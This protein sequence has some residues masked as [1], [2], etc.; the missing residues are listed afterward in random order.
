[1][2]TSSIFS[3]ELANLY[4]E[5]NVKGIEEYVTSCIDDNGGLQ[6]ERFV[7]LNPRF[8]KDETLNL[9][10]KEVASVF[11][12]STD[13]LVKEMKMPIL[14]GLDFF[15]IPGKF[16]LQKSKIYT[17]GR[18]YGQDLSS[19]AAVAA[20]SI[21]QKCVSSNEPFKVLDLCCCPGVK[22]CAIADLIEGMRKASTVK[23]ISGDV[24]MGVDIDPQRLYVCRKIVKKYHID[25]LL[26]SGSDCKMNDCDRNVR[27]MLYNSDGT[28]FSVQNRGKLF[29]DTVAEKEELKSCKTGNNRKRMNKS[30][31]ARERKRL[32]ALEKSENLKNNQDSNQDGF[33]DRVLVD[34]ECSTDGSIK[35]LL[36]RMK[37]KNDKD[38]GPNEKLS[39]KVLSSNKSG[40]L[41]E[42][43]KLQRN[44][45]VAGFQNLRKDGV[46]V[47]STC[48]L[49]RDQNEE[50]VRHLLE[51]FANAFIIP[52]QSNDVEGFDGYAFLSDWNTIRFTFGKFGGFFLAK[53]GKR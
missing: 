1:M 32:K 25:S 38:V 22:F 17:E 8:C 11:A 46:M 35:H 3:P 14:K 10:K 30:A 50:M 21:D 45:I 15:S 24:V 19:G 44:L 39:T 2:S 29:F 12:S 41:D 43:H 9:L 5:N 51:T 18:I 4:K 36:E 42:L 27:L 47:Y 34:A 23:G 28:N 26:T 13:D 16:S 33:F 53:I 20:L 40:N 31:R 49:S 52:F 7:R 48:S 6:S 37:K